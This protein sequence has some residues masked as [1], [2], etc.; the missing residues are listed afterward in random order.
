RVVDGVLRNGMKIAFGAHR[1]D[2]YDVDEVGYLQLD[3]K[4]AEQLEAG[5]VGYFV[6]NVRGVRETRPG[7]TVLAADHRDV[8]LLPGYRDIQSMVF[9]GLYPMNAEQ[10]EELRDALAK[11]QL[12]DASLHYEPETSVALG[13]GFRCGF[14]GLLHMEIVRERLEREFD[15]DLI[16]TVPNVEY[17]IYKTD[18]SMELVENPSLLPH[19]SEVDRI[20]EPYVKA[21][22]FAPSEYI[23]GIM[24]LGQERRGVYG[25]MKYLD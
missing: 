9:A 19:G 4:P 23:G 24:N 21:R 12:N 11:L 25:G 16:S 14:L 18:G 5:E 10:Y 6:A 15:L 22:I 8:P 7:D 3:R 17:H 20:E 13:F 2:T 1:D